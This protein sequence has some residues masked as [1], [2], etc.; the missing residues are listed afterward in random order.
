MELVRLL[1]FA[2]TVTYLL[3]FAVV[4]ALS[5]T[6]AAQAPGATQSPPPRPA[7][8]ASG[9]QKDA[10][11]AT[12]LSVGVTLGGFVVAGVS[13]GEPSVALLGGVGM[14][15]GPSTG[16][17]YAGRVG[18]IGLA[19]RA[20]AA[21]VIVKGITLR[22]TDE[23]DIMG[24][25]ADCT[26]LRDRSQRDFHNG[27]RLILAGLG[28]WI[29]SSVFDI[30]MAR[31]AVHTWNREHAVALTPTLMPAAGGRA[32]GVTLQLSF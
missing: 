6:A 4:L 28:L 1:L 8:P 26:E 14:Y 10:G 20:V 29:G 12:M 24:C 7:Q 31:R 17:W 22:D 30:V 19:A 15:L 5:S 13:G 21:I 18:G 9:D 3:P 23:Y 11:T 27:E 25:T 2:T 16:Q 32:P